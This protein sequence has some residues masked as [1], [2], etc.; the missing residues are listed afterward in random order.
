[1]RGREAPAEKSLLS[2][3]GE[4]GLLLGCVVTSPGS[5][6][7]RSAPASPAHLCGMGSGA[8]P[9]AQCEL[10]QAESCKAQL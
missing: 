1:M 9:C 3:S 6:G 8:S 10:M 4:A 7:G 5:P 2:I